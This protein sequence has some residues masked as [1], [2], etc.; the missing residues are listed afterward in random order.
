MSKMNFFD[1]AEKMF[2][3]EILPPEEIA[4]KL[5]ISRRTIYYWVK[6]FDWN[7]KKA[8]IERN[9][10]ALSSDLITFL[11]TLML[12]L[13]KDMADKTTINQSELYSL[14]NLL[15]E[16]PEMHKYEKLIKQTKTN[17]PTGQLSPE[18]VQQVQKEILGM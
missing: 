3:Y 1:E 10:K 13:T 7:K 6:K 4:K 8:E 2:L 18:F 14:I 17:E 9:K 15:K 12:K 16:I 11:K 5:K